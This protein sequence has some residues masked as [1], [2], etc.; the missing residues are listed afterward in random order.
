[1]NETRNQ[2]MGRYLTFAREQQQTLEKLSVEIINLNR[3]VSDVF[4]TYINNE[5]IRTVNNGI[6]NENNTNSSTTTTS[7]TDAT[8]STSTT[9]TAPTTPRTIA[10][11]PQPPP[12]SRSRSSNNT[13]SGPVGV[14]NRSSRYQLDTTR[15]IT[16]V[17]RHTTETTLVHPMESTRFR[18]S[19][20]SRIPRLRNRRSS[21]LE[22]PNI[23]PPPPP[24]TETQ[25]TETS[26]ET[27]TDSELI[28]LLPEPITIPGAATPSDTNVTTNRTRSSRQSP[29][30]TAWQIDLNTPASRVTR[31]PTRH[32]IFRIGSRELPAADILNQ[33]L[34]DSPVRIRPSVVQVRR[35][36]NVISWSDISDNYQ[37]E[38]PIDMIPFETGDSILQI[39]ECKHIFREMN[40]RRHFRNSPRCPLCRYDIRDYIQSENSYSQSSLNDTENNQSL[41]RSVVDDLEQ[42]ITDL[43]ESASSDSSGNVLDLSY[44]LQFPSMPLSS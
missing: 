35:A 17:S 42:N 18:T 25:E 32:R 30:T 6:R 34:F 23:P 26:T 1:M 38:C 36:T 24:P 29:L 20:R 37:T 21:L 27:A 14:S 13:D 44:D 8:S 2:I 15:R 5:T 28:P 40:L 10:A 4:V 3:R 43:L 7:S 41:I 19:L 22:I 16:G 39:R 33:T 12:P 9:P 31:R 11:I